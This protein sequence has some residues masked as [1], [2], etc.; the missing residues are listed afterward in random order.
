MSLLLKTNN[1]IIFF[2]LFF[3]T[4][5][6]YTFANQIIFDDLDN[7]QSSRNDYLSEFNIAN[8]ID[9][10]WNNFFSNQSFD[11]INSFINSLPVQNTDEVFQKIIF[12]ILISKKSFNRSYV[13]PDE[14]LVLFESLINK[15]FETGRLSEIELIYSQTTELENNNFILKKMI[16][17]NLLRNR[18]SEAC[19]IL[20]KVNQDPLYFGKIMIICDIIENKFD[21]AKLGLQLL[22]EQNQPGDIFFIDLAYSLMSDKDI[23][24]SDDLKKNLNKIKD[25]NPIIMSSLQFADISPNFEHIEKLSTSGLLF[26]LSNPSVDTELKIFCSEML[27]RQ[28]RINVEM[29]SEAYQLAMFESKEIRNAEKIYKSLSPVRA[30]PLLYQSIIRDNKPESKFRKIIAL[31]KI[32]MNDDLLPKISYLV[33]D[34]LKFE[35][36]VRNHE[37]SIL[38]SQMYQ[39]R[40]NFT[41][42]RNILDKFYQSPES[43][44]R[45]LAIDVSEFISNNIIDYSSLEIKLEKLIAMEK[46]NSTFIKKVLMVLITNVDLSENQNLI[47][48]LLSIT[49]DSNEKTINSKNLFLAEKLSSSNDYFNSLLLLFKISGDKEFLKLNLIES[50]SIL[51]ILKNLGFNEEFK[52][53]SEQILL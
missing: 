16:E 41:A 6:H 43:D 35:D 39:S 44:F 17:G 36:Y 30:R 48:K 9:N 25:L 22:K 34:L 33:G 38:L 2:L 24:Q 31:I 23:T 18:H 49:I 7:F 1:I 12:D 10:K 52:K 27:V 50:Y 29:L 37:D 32:S 28:D 42:A 20:Q 47:N 4:Q 15:L 40:K 21:E 3:T 46:I 13:S 26:I 14:D 45:N 8:E 51:I 53:L 11:K 19:K 5:F